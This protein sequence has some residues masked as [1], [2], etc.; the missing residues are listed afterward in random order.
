MCIIDAA[1][2]SNSR[3]G[4][5]AGAPPA[6]SSLSGDL[7]Q[8]V[9]ICG[10]YTAGAA[11]AGMGCV[12]SG[13]QEQQ[14]QQLGEQCYGQ[15]QQQQQQEEQKQVEAGEDIY[16]QQEGNYYVSAYDCETESYLIPVAHI[17]ES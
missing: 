9:G 7:S 16:E 15:Q 17:G 4:S 6:R 3:A 13:N 10:S 12:S 8:D 1:I 11:A 14:Q 2:T 5:I